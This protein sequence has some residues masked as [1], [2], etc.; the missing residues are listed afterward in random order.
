MRELPEGAWGHSGARHLTWLLPAA[1]GGDVAP[2]AGQPG[3]GEQDRG[4]FGAAGH[5]VSA[6]SRRVE[7][8]GVILVAIDDSIFV[9]TDLLVERE[10]IKQRIAE[11]NR[12]LQAQPE[13]RLEPGIWSPANTT[14]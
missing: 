11:I 10:L 3:D 9:S 2:A 12:E 8:G 6:G 14:E 4:H 7:G 13:W 5:R 1:P